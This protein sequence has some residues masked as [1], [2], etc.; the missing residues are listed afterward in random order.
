MVANIFIQKSTE[1][2]I[3]YKAMTTGNGP[4]WTPE[5]Y[6]EIDHGLVRKCWR[7]SV[8]DTTTDPHTNINTDHYMMTVKIRQALKAREDLKHDPSLKHVTTPKGNEEDILKGFTHGFQIVIYL[9]ELAP[10]KKRLLF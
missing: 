1:N 3:T 7:N 4:P 10:P 5:K 8:L 2:K 6:Y 9:L